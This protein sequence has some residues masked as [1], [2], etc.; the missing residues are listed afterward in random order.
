MRFDRVVKDILKIAEATYRWEGNQRWMNSSAGQG[1]WS[2]QAATIPVCGPRA[3]PLRFGYSAGKPRGMPVLRISRSA[4][5]I[6]RTAD[7][8][9]RPA[10]IAATAMSGHAVAD[11]HTPAP[12][13]II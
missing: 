11:I 5:R 2:I 12:A 3:R 1:H 7:D 4:C 8:S 9:P 6:I 10:M 13:S